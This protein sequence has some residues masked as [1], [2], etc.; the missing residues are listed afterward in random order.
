MV[1]FDVEMS[2]TEFLRMLMALK[3]AESHY[4]TLG[5]FDLAIAVGKQHAKF[6]KQVTEFVEEED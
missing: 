5:S 2:K 3:I 1:R 6:L 4:T